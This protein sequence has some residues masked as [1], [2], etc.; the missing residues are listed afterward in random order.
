[1]KNV[2]M[3]I[4][5]SSILVVLLAFFSAPF[6][7]YA[8]PDERKGENCKSK[9]PDTNLIDKRFISR[10]QC[11]EWE[12]VWCLVDEQLGDVGIRCKIIIGLMSEKE[13]DNRN[14]RFGGNILQYTLQDPRYSD[15]LSK[16]QGYDS[17]KKTC[18]VAGDFANCMKITWNKNYSTLKSVCE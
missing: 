17:A 14:K 6:K 2:P 3:H 18:A 1:M 7:S 16:C 11:N 13:K 15:K 4:V 5:A 8:A 9:N 10:P 12:Q